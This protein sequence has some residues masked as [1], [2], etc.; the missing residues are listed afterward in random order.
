MIGLTIA[1]LL[2]TS[3]PIVEAP[4]APSFRMPVASPKISLGY[5]KDWLDAAYCDHGKLLLHTG[6]DLNIRSQSTP[7]FA[8]ANGVVRYARSY[9]SKVINGRHYDWAN[10][11]VLE[12]KLSDGSLVTSLYG[13]IEF[14]GKVK[15]AS[16]EGKVTVNKGDQIGAI[17]GRTSPPHLHFGIRRGKFDV[18]LSRYGALPQCGQAEKDKKPPFPDN[19]VEPEQFIRNSN[20]ADGL[21]RANN[22][23]TVFLV[24]NKVRRAFH[25]EPCF[26]DW[27]KQMSKVKV[28]DPVDL[29]AATKASPPISH[30]LRVSGA[31]D[32][33]WVVESFDPAGTGKY[34]ARLIHDPFRNGKLF[35]AMGFNAAD[36]K[37]VLFP[38]ARRY[39]GG[40]ALV[41]VEP[42]LLTMQGPFCRF[43]D[44]QFSAGWMVRNMSTAKLTGM[45]ITTRACQ[46]DRNGRVTG[47][48]IDFPW[49][50]TGGIDSARD[51]WNPPYTSIS[52]SQMPRGNFWMKVIYS[53]KVGGRNMTYGS[54]SYGAEAYPYNETRIDAKEP[55]SGSRP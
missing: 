29:Y 38:P 22:E 55:E 33:Y 47:R 25:T 28:I 44:D 40:I 43:A 30:L 31:K 34:V 13:H 2:G 53:Y 50:G 48:W 26:L 45:A 24:E 46:L 27:G 11:V 51:P 5:G 15:D 37:T 1:F 32:I 6:L 35:Q 16:S 7:V 19:W 9:G 52:N 18:A 42:R 3:A 54:P 17:S 4:L 21:Y 20:F 41:E 14:A 10:V 8:A 49:H 23:Q 12:H 36:V 39:P